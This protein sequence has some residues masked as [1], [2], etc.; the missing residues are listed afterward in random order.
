MSI[1]VDADTKVL[2][3]GITGREASARVRFMR[4][5]GTCVIGGVSPGHG[6][7]MV[8]NVLVF[9]S[10]RE[11]IENLGVTPDL[12]VAFVPPTAQRDA[13]LEAMEGRIRLLV[14]IADH[15]PIH[16]VMVL[17]GWAREVGTTFIGPNCAGI[18]SPGAAAVGMLGGNVVT[19]R[20]FFLPGSVGVVSRSGGLAAAAAYMLTMHGVGQSTV[21]HVGGDA[22]VGMRLPDV[23]LEFER[24][25]RTQAIVIVGEI[26]SVQEED[27]AELVVSGAISKPVFAFINGAAAIGNTRFSHAGAIVEAGRGS[28][29][30][31]KEA[32]ARAGIAVV[33]SLDALPTVVAQHLNR[34]E[35]LG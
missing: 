5:Y 7:E 31:K 10:V 1:L 18:V 34:M 3:Q 16:D 4:E 35:K 14:L 8:E 25:P 15:V 32:F 17:S 11:A 26:G 9:D 28:Y 29:A 33:D 13:A 6:G 2:V 12:A 23:L 30:S 20:R 19:A 24:D 27:S 22:I 21:V